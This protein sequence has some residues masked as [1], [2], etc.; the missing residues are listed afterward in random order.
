MS[1]NNKGRAKS[2]TKDYKADAVKLA[3]TIGITKLT[4][5]FY[6]VGM[7]LGHS[8]KG[9]GLQLNIS[10]NMEAMTAKYVDVRLERKKAVLDA[11]HN[12]LHPKPNGADAKGKKTKPEQ[13]KS[14]RKKDVERD[15]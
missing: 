1:E 6:T 15:L 5:D 7:I 8:L 11:Y 14:E 3:R 4:G 13:G 12:A 2:Y 9:V 10:T